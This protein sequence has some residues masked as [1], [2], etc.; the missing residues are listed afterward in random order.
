MK[1]VIL[2]LASYNILVASNFDYYYEKCKERKFI[3]FTNEMESKIKEKTVNKNIERRNSISGDYRDAI[4]F[5]DIFK[6]HSKD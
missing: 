4:R 3:E 6:N 2:L 1:T 5:S